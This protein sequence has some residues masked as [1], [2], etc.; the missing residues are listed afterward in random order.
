M[1]S[2]L[3]MKRGTLRKFSELHSRRMQ[4]VS[5]RTQRV[6]LMLFVV[7]VVLG[8]P[9]IVPAVIVLDVSVI[10]ISR[11]R[12][13]A[14]GFGGSAPAHPGFKLLGL[15]QVQRLLLQ[16]CTSCLMSGTDL[17][18]CAYQRW[19]NLPHHQVASPMHPIPMAACDARH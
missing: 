5:C 3:E 1:T 16:L 13:C 15:G 4:Q 9:T 19:L 11:N 7:G 18:Y 6:L 2:A 8:A 14:S 12:R 17:G 10:V